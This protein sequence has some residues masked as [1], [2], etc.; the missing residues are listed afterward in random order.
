M[1]ALM[2]QRGA[3]P[4]QMKRNFVTISNYLQTLNNIPESEKDA[5][6][7]IFTKT[8]MKKVLKMCP[9]SIGASEAQEIR[10]YVAK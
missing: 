4:M 1:T 2:D 7:N 10:K 6:I 8:T 9:N 5:K 3:Q